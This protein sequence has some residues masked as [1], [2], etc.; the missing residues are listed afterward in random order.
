[1][2]RTIWHPL[3]HTEQPKPSVKAIAV[4]YHMQNS[5][6]LFFYFFSKIVGQNLKCDAAKNYSIMGVKR[7]K[8]AGNNSASA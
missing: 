6:W 2:T 4:P 8:L 1:M 3:E 5:S 7:L